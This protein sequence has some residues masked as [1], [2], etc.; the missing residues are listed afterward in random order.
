MKSTL[1]SFALGL[2]LAAGFASVGL[3][4]G[5]YNDIG[6]KTWRDAPA[7][8]PVPA[9]VPVPT[10]PSGW[11]LRADIGVGFADSPKIT[12]NGRLFGLTDSPGPANTFASPT[13]FGANPAW[14]NSDFN[15]FVSGGI[16]AGYNWGRGFRSDVT[17]EARTIGKADGIGAYSYQR[18]ALQDD[19]T[20][21]G[22]NRYLPVV[23]ATGRPVNINGAYNDHTEVD[24]KVFLFNAYYDVAHW[25][26]FKPYIGAGIGFTY[27][28]VSRDSTLVETNSSTG[29]ATTTTNN[30]NRDTFGLAAAATAGVS[31][32]LT[33]SISLDVNYRYLYLQG[34]TIDLPYTGGTS[35][36]SLGDYGE[37]A[38]R[39]GLRFNID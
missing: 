4:G 35:R 26:P 29:V 18:Y 32:D 1:T 9:P 27:S 33:Q 14:F 28:R 24:T 8:V 22:T 23:D 21:T 20:G 37:H 5:S 36:V 31:Y 17:A 19:G 34:S 39:T 25:G 7:A 16:G 6:I 11:Y 30:Q 13:P 15:T 38:L 12:Q 3:A 10:T 2:G